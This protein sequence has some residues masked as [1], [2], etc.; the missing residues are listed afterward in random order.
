MLPLLIV[1]LSLIVGFALGGR[2]SSLA[3]LKLR[4]IPLVFAALAI[5]LLIFP[6]VSEVAPLAWAAQPLHL[7]S[8][9]LLAA[10]IIRHLHL[11]P[12]ILL[13]VGAAANLLVLLSNRGLMPASVRALQRA[14]WY[15][16]AEQLL[17]EGAVANLVLMSSETR[18]NVLGDW[19]Y[20]PA[21]IPLTTAFSIGDVLIMLALSWLIVRGM[22]SHA[23]RSER[24]SRTP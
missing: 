14:G 1:P 5:Q 6:T 21:W 13:G 11:A 2:L 10:W 20:L 7:L 16:L 24:I 12:V 3:H 4:W 23:E 22:R 18:C 17:R 19:L 8:Y 9:L 15:D